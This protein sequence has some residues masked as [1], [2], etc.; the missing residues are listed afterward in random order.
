MHR[1][2][3]RADRALT[4]E[5]AL[6]ILQNGEYGILSTVSSDGQPYGVPVSYCCVGIR[7]F[8][9]CAVEGHKLENLA[10]NPRVSFCVVGRTE[11]LPGQFATRY[12][13]AI[14]F[15]TAVELTG[16]EKLLA[17][18]ELLKKYSPDFLEKGQRY[19]E[20]DAGKTRVYQIEIETVTG[21]ARK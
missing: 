15:G 11:V 14:V 3:R 13:S 12:E 6:E 5:Q 16:D 18:T 17:L 19:I 4:Q 2:I 20:S 1:P 8:F 9:H 10:A 21:K 7:L